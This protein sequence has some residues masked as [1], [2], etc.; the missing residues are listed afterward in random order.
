M[1]VCSIFQGRTLIKILGGAV[2]FLK[3]IC[4]YFLHQKTKLKK[5]KKKLNLYFVL[6]F[7]YKK[8]KTFNGVPIL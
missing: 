2:R 6:K 8:G 4:D 1:K 3:N 7:Q 5:K